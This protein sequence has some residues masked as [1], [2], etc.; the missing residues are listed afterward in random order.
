MNELE[1][2]GRKNLLLWW[3]ERLD[4]SGNKLKN[5]EREDTNKIFIS[6]VFHTEWIKRRGDSGKEYTTTEGESYKYRNRNHFWKG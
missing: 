1:E 2:L 3:L 5:W 6:T 4:L